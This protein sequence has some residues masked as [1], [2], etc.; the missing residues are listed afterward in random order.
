MIFSKKFKLKKYSSNVKNIML[1]NFISSFVIQGIF[2]VFIGIHIKTLGF[3]ESVVGKVLAVNSLSIGFGSLLSA[4]CLG[5]LGRKKS[6]IIGVIT[7]CIGMIGIGA[8]TQVSNLM[9]FA[10]FTGIG[11]SFPSTSVGVLLAENSRAEE[12]VGVFS[13]NFVIQSIGVICG[14][15]LGGG[16]NGIFSKF[17][18]LRNVIPIMFYICALLVLVMIIPVLK[19]KETTVKTAKKSKNLYIT[20]RKI[21]NQKKACGFIIYNTIIGFGAG[22]V[23]PFFSVYLKYQLNIDSASVGGIMAL[24][25]V[26]LVIGGIS[27]PYVSKIL[28]KENTIIICQLLSIPF[29]ISIA[30]PQGI[31]IVAISFLLRSTLM[32]LN[33]PLIQNISMD[34]VEEE[35]RALMSS[36]ILMTSYL[37][38]AVSV[39]I[40]GYVMENISYNLPYYVTVVLYLS[41]TYT[42]YKFF[43]KIR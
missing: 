35:D 38:R 14:S 37:T 17:F 32:N 1:L 22:L 16:L 18:D 33:Q 19:L 41:G 3:G 25:Q 26:G 12:K 27:V 30:F 34:I 13:R 21:M 28:G 24:S 43:R 42:F 20:F 39:I 7:I 9:F 29:L 5:I 6:L 2:F 8:S 23:V 4:Y 36:L 40:A 11:Y 15:Y 31:V 10:I